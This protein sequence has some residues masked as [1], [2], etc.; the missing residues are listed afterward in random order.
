MGPEKK[1][2]NFSLP[3]LFVGALPEW[4]LFEIKGNFV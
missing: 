2:M 1:K 4:D 3:T